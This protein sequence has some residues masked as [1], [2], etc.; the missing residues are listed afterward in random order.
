MF[1]FVGGWVV[2]ICSCGF[3]AY[4]AFRLYV[5]DLLLLLLLLFDY[6]PLFAFF[7]SKYRPRLAGGRGWVGEGGEGLVCSRSA[8][9]QDSEFREVRETK[10][11]RQK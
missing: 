11:Q 8:L 3:T 7:F 10:R 4:F 5:R 2:F 1:C 9:K 6:R